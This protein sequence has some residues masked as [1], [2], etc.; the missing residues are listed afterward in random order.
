MFMQ[1]LP[2]Y[3]RPFLLFF[4][5]IFSKLLYFGNVPFFQNSL[6]FL[7]VHAH[8]ECSVASGLIWLT[9]LA[10]VSVLFLPGINH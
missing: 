7:S 1:L 4:A 3:S 10:E 8:S 5:S 2:P 6:L 9:E